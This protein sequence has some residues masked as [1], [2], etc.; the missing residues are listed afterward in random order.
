MKA[1]RT[2]AT[3]HPMQSTQCIAAGPRPLNA[4]RAATLLLA[5]QTLVSLTACSAGAARGPQPSAPTTPGAASC[6]TPPTGPGNTSS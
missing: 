2:T 4:R 5:V 1:E 6:T 3:G